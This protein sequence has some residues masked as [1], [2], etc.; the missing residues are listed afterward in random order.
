MAK[1]QRVSPFRGKVNN[2]AKR[3]S[4]NNSGFG[5]LNL[6]KGVVLYSPVPGQKESIDIIPYIVSDPKHPD[7]NAEAGIAGVG[8]LWYKRPY[9]THRQVGVNNETV[10][11]LASFGKK[12]PICEYKK[13]RTKE[14]AEK[15]ELKGY[16]TSNRNL[17]VI[18]PIGVKKREEEIHIFDFSQ[19]NFQDLLNEELEENE[20]NEIFPDIE[21]GL[22]LAVRWAEEVFEKNK[23]AKAGRIDFNKRKSAYDESILDD[24]PDLD[25]VLKQLTYDELSAK[26]F[27]MEGVEDVDDAPKRKTKSK[28]V[29][30][31]EEEDEAPK[32]RVG[33]TVSTKNKVK[34]SWGDLSDMDDTELLE[35]AES[36][37]LEID[38][39]DYSS[40]SEL[41]KLIADTLG[42]TIPNPK[43]RQQIVEIEEE[44]EEDEAPK[45]RVGKPARKVVEPDEEEEEDLTSPK[46]KSSKTKGKKEED[47]ECPEGME[48]GVDTDTD[49]ACDDCPLWGDCSDKKEGN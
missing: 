20:D 16:N 17:Y 30:E 46:K 18:I 35:V 45:K 42:V 40:T 13:Q 19:F 7:A 29:E 38:E 3:Q 37:A 23:Y 34:L 15:D 47:E 27:E 36:Y 8:D 33:K 24:V 43:K 5:H 31:E 9:K 28:I 26:F 12:C 32:K 21:E 11:C 1:K 14:G 22:T 4:R 39:D 2:D 10:V 25:K 6:P 48:F 41:A 44:E 49:T